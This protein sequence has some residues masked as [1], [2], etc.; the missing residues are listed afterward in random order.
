MRIFEA[1]RIEIERFELVD[2]IAVSIVNSFPP[3]FTLPDDEFEEEE[4]EE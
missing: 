3:L 2:T 4:G 1:P